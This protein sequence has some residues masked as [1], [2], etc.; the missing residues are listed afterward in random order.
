MVLPHCPFIAPRTLFDYYYERVNLPAVEENQPASVEHFRRVRGILDPPL[1]DERVRIARAAYYGLCEHLDVQIGKVLEAL[2]ST[3]LADRT[4]VVYCSDHGEMAGQHGCWWKSNYYQ[5]SV[6]VPLIARLPGPVRSAGVSEA[7]VNLMDIGPTLVDLGGAAPGGGVES[8]RWDGRSM[9]RLLAHGSDPDWVDETVS[10][11]VDKRGGDPNLPSRMVRS[12]PWKLWEFGGPVGLSP[13]LFNLEDD[14]GELHDLSGD[15]AYREVRDRL[16]E[17][18]H[19]DWDPRY[20][21][22]AA[23]EAEADHDV[24]AAWGRVTL[25]P[26]E[27]TLAAPPPELEAE[28]ELL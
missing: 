1:P 18:L 26:C 9:A 17:R 6:G 25:P 7:V 23:A 16:L 12:G 2:D 4:M 11:L 13:A 5:G 27:D 22:A 20:A 3:G 15:P 14:P 8:L 19:R 28:A 21:S 24:L 10:E